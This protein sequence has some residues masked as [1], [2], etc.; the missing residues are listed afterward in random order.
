[1]VADSRIAALVRDLSGRTDQA[2]ASLVVEQLAATAAGVRLAR[3]AAAGELAPAVARQRMGAVEHEGDAGR[4][5]LVK[6]LRRSVSSPIDR[7]DLF[8]LSR[9]VDD[10]LDALR[11]FVREFDLFQAAPSPAYAPVLDALA[12]S[13]DH[14]SEA[15]RLL[16]A[17][18]RRAADEALLAK[19]PGVRPRYQHA[20]ADLLGG[21]V[22]ADTLR[23]T[24]LLGRLDQAGTSLAAAVDA[25][26]DGVVKRFQ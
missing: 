17:A 2:L 16:P 22:D 3:S 12:A 14:L 18:P 4:A 6:R 24:L 21:P 8:R 9:A 1:M 23:D 13:V 25:L 20:V 15:V 11:D 19:K 26:A 10:V 7:E 5:L